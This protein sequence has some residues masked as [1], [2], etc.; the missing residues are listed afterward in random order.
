MTGD[1]VGDGVFVA[2]GLD[3]IG[4]FEGPTAAA[5]SAESRGTI[6]KARIPNA[7]ASVAIRRDAFVT[8]RDNGEDRI[9][10]SLLGAASLRR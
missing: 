5:P 2:I 6:R 10:S 4:A 9:R 8:E 1:G 7:I 3:P